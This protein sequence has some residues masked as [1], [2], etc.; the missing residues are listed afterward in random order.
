MIEIKFKGIDKCHFALNNEKLWRY[1][2]LVIL[3][4]GGYR[5]GNKQK[6]GND[7]FG[8]EVIPETVGQYTGLKDKNGAEIYEGDIVRAGL[9]EFLF[10]V[11]FSQEYVQFKIIALCRNISVSMNCDIEYTVIGNIHDNR[12]LLEVQ[13]ET[14]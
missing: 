4:N 6:Y 10:E 11:G 13:N 12:E 1:G 7:T 3:E 2:S 5:I 14:E 8:D 9:S